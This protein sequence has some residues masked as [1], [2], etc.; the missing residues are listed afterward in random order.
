MATGSGW[1]DLLVDGWQGD[2]DGARTASTLGPVGSQAGALAVPLD[3]EVAE[4]GEVV[5]DLLPTGRLRA[6]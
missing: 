2:A 5:D 4:M 1:G 6:A 3:F